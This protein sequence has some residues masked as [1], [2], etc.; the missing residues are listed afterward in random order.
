[1]SGKTKDVKREADDL[2]DGVVPIALPAEDSSRS[3][4][5]L[6]DD[7]FRWRCRRR[8]N[9]GSDR[10]GVRSFPPANRVVNDLEVMGQGSSSGVNSLARVARVDVGAW[11][12][13]EVHGLC[14]LQYTQKRRSAMDQEHDLPDTSGASERTRFKLYLS[15]KFLPHM[16]S[17]VGSTNVQVA[18]AVGA[19]DPDPAYDGVGP[20]EGEGAATTDEIE[21]ERSSPC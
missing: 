20:S 10:T 8:S 21:D 15:K 14:V 13:R 16:R 18:G 2:Q 5:Y 3:V 19:V 7:S 12:G 11:L 6:A 9:L 17:V 1:M 4:E